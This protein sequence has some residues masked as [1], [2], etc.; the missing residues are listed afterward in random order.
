MKISEP[1]IV[2]VSP[3]ARVTS[4]EMTSDRS[5]LRDPIARWLLMVAGLVAAMVSVGGYVRLSRAGLSIVEWDVF[6]GVLPPIGEPAWQ[7]T[8]AAYQETPEFQLV[9]SQ[10]SLSDYRRIF[11][12][13]W[14]HRL[15]ARVVGLI[16]ILP[17]FWFLR[18]G[19]LTMRASLQ[20]WGVVALFGLQGLMGW[21]MVSSGLRDQPLVSH[22]RLTIHFL[23]A[24]ALF[25]L[26]LWLAFDRMGL[27]GP[28]DG[29][30]AAADQNV[31]RLLLASLVVQLGYGGL[32]AGLRAGYMSN[33]WPLMYGRLIPAG[34][35]STAESWWASLVEPLTS[36]WIH[37]WLAFAV[38]AIAA[39]MFARIRR[40]YGDS[41]LLWLSGISLVGLVIVQIALGVGVVWFGVPKWLALA[42][43]GVGGGD[44]RF[45]R[46][47]R[48]R[49][50]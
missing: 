33:T 45:R 42:H 12:I 43:Q 40:R 25:G 26:V 16:V 10:I 36:L 49:A 17:L 47:H 1:K 7:E 21:L 27:R 4:C 22:F 29:P 34:L 38:A 15:I 9:N 20:Y 3:L 19:L 46:H 13:E 28:N 24:L 5:G 6:G 8:F 35:L 11:Y 41:R 48:L 30:I 31:S 32:V 23:M 14:A 50:H 37:R 44:V 18:K 39:V 2:A